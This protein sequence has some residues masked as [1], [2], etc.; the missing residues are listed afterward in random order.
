MRN[1]ADT[2]LPAGVLTLYDASGAAIFAGD[3]RLGGLPAGESRLLSFAQDLRTTVERN[4]SGKRTLVALTA[5]DGVLHVTFRDR[6]VFRVTINAPAAEGRHVLVEFAKEADSKFSVEGPPIPGI[7]ETAAAW[8]VPV[9]VGQGEVRKLTAYRDRMTLEQL[10]LISEDSN[11]DTQAVVNILNEQ[12]LDSRARAALEHIVALRQDEARQRGERARLQAQL[13]AVTEDEDRIR[14]N[15]DAVSANDAL[16]T[17]LT[18][19]LDAD[20][21]R[22][23]QL[24]QSIDQAEGAV[25]R[26]HQTLADA[27]RSLRL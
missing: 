23:T 3:A 15:L 24:Q 6:E 14:K 25:Q 26:A 16:H 9:S 12:T 1:N 22:I 17:R 19:A 20:E 18:R 21:T 5:A 8:R 4:E 27:V 2:S 13:K 11:E 10:A 7:E